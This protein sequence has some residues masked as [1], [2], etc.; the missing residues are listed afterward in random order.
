MFE[1][2]NRL[3]RAAEIARVL[4]VTPWRVYWLARKGLLP[5]VRLGHQVR[6]APDAVAEFIASG[7]KA[8][9]ATEEP[10]SHPTSGE[11]AIA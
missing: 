5:S 6:F 3:H 9:S 10:E 2:R 8:L 7:G 1:E 4:H 11:V